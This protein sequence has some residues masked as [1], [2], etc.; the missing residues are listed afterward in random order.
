MCADSVDRI[1][2]V[3][4]EPIERSFLADNLCADG[5]EV[6]T[7]DTAAAAQRLLFTNFIDLAVI[8][9][10]LPDGDGLELLSLVRGADR[11][12]GRVDPDLPLLVLS[13]RASEIDRVRG[14]DRGA[15]DYVCKPYSYP[16]L[17][18]RITL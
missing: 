11:A 6:L 13:G 16:E 8:D 12:L 4:D 14:F 18:R 17:L 7:A 3:D 15:D 10:G 5:F 1:L 2:L 9:L